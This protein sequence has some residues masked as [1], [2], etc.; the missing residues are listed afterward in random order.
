MQVKANGSIAESRSWR[1]RSS[2]VRGP[3][4][5]TGL[6]LCVTEVT[7]HFVH[8]VKVGIKV[9]FNPTPRVPKDSST[10]QVKMSCVPGCQAN[11]C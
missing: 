3:C 10:D 6:D 2:D 11:E 9:Y 5:S 1:I 7:S 4:V 8:E